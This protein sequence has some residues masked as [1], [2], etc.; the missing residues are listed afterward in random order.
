MKPYIIGETAFHHEGDFSYLKRMVEDIAEIRL[1]AIKFQVRFNIE[2]YMQKGHPLMENARKWTFSQSQWEEVLNLALEKKLDIVVLCHD[3]EAIQY[4]NQTYPAI[5]AIEL[6]ANALNDYFFLKEAAKFRN[7]VILG[8][9]GST[10]DEIEYAVR[11]L[12][13]N[14]KQDILLMYGFQSYPTD[15]T[16]INLSKMLKLK[17]LFA[18]PVAYA[19]HTGYDDPN[20]VYVSASAAAM[21]VNVLEKHYTPQPGVKRIDYQAAVGKEQLGKIRELMELFL[22]IHGN[23]RLDMSKAEMAYGNT[24]P[25]KK[26]IVA[27]NNIK[28][29]EELSLENLWFKRTSDEAILKQK[30]LLELLG[31]KANQNIEEDEIIDFSK[32]EYKYNQMSFSDL[33]GGLEKR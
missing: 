4:I 28:K 27:K 2:N 13:N 30:Q 21:G 19:D 5:S 26:A 32:V 25:M 20:N 24:G 3:F 15:Y 6:H 31:L 9:G 14:G 18:V 23:G 16:R 11:M 33:T 17:E 8:V 7:R 22:Q 10:L 12:R 1:D 29:G